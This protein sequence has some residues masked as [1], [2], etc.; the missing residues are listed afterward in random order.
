M[1]HD[2]RNTDRVP[3][4]DPSFGV[5]GDKWTGEKTVHGGV[6]EW[7]GPS[8]HARDSVPAFPAADPLPLPTR[9]SRLSRSSQ[10]VCLLDVHSRQGS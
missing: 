2:L 4:N 1:F 6:G 5:S 9:R 7:E 3:R 8:P 10:I